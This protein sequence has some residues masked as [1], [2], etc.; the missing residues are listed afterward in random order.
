MFIVVLF[1][2]AKGGNNAL[3][4]GDRWRNTV[5]SLQ[6]V[7]QHLAL[8]RNEVP[9]RAA[10]WMNLESIVLRQRRSQK[11]TCYRIPLIGKVRRGQLQRNGTQSRLVVVGAEEGRMGSAC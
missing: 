11:A 8:K 10:T 4:I 7:Q 2:A 3:S 9:V 6:T 1:T 5:W